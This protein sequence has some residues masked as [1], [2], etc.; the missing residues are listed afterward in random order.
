LSSPDSLVSSL[1]L[2]SIGRARS[3][4]GL[5]AVTRPGHGR[6]VSLDRILLFGIRGEIMLDA[7]FSRKGIGSKLLPFVAALGLQFAIIEPTLAQTL[8]TLYTFTGGNA[9]ANPTAG[10]VWGNGNLYGTTSYGGKY[11][12]GTLFAIGSA[13]N[14]AVLTPFYP[15]YGDTPLDAPI[16][17]GSTYF[18]GLGQ[19]FL[20]TASAGGHYGCGAI[21]L[22]TNT[23]YAI[24]VY[25]FSG[26][27][28]G[29]SPMGRLV[30]A[31]GGA[32]YGTASGGGS[33]SA[34]TI[35]KIAKDGP[36]LQ[37]R[38]SLVYT[39]TGGADG[40][41]PQGTLILDKQGNLYGTTSSGGAYGVGAVFEINDAGETVLYS[42]K[43]GSDGANPT[44]DLLLDSKGDFYGT[45][46]GGGAS[47]LGTVYE[48]NAGGV[49]TM[50]YGFAGGSDGARPA[51]GV[52]KD[53]NENLY[54]TTVYGGSGAVCN[55][56]QPLNGCGTVF[57]ISAQGRETVLYS[58]T[59]G[60]DGGEPYGKL[61]RDEQ[62]NLYGTA[63]QGGDLESCSEL[64]CGVVFELTP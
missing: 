13:G 30:R 39:F 54:G 52:I 50:F 7:R 5:L 38:F 11:G 57:E 1:L 17:G 28:D 41:A 37:Y 20:L 18:M 33:S 27:A 34:G 60:A 47:G 26:G 15:D 44:G 61:T 32:F 45:T 49:E 16:V 51:A 23:G 58:F 4:L 24:P 56:Y 25:S 35:F 46:S 40:G 21:I 59:G 31:G 9:G 6:I 19:E 63:S 62:G 42:F 3:F 8:T 36:Y 2:Q 14:E 22:A 48:V 29:C 10:L 53:G 55:Q 12:G 64:G 43:G